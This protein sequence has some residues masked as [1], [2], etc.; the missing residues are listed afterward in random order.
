MVATAVGG[1]PEQVEHGVTGFLVPPGNAEA[2]ASRIE[3][4][5]SDD[6]PR[7]EMGAQAAKAARMRFNL[8]QQ[9]NKYLHW[10]QEILEEWELGKE[11]GH[12]LSNSE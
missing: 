11:R 4:M 7:R 8:E 3:Q 10:Y 12:A 1:I 6:K 5:L 9:V 2:M